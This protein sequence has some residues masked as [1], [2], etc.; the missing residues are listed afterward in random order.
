MNQRVIL[1]DSSA[2]KYY[3]IHKIVLEFTVIFFIFT[4]IQLNDNS[5][6]KTCLTVPLFL[7]FLMA[8]FDSLPGVLGR[9]M[10]WNEEKGR[11][12]MG[13]EDDN[14]MLWHQTMS[15]YCDWEVGR[16]RNG[17][18]SESC[19]LIEGTGGGAVRVVKAREAVVVAERVGCEASG[20]S[21]LRH[22]A[23]EAAHSRLGGTGVWRLMVYSC[24][25]FQEKLWGRRRDWK[26]HSSHSAKWLL[27]G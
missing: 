12:G 13:G 14:L 9:G 8:F 5:N 19:G 1:F 2:R 26:E 7:G 18:N 22:V 17:T 20:W 10:W 15:V 27:K 3:W 21:W 4:L 23:A 24:F 25:V 11:W 16:R 6:K